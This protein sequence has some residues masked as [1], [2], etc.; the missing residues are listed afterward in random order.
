MTVKHVIAY[1]APKNKTMAHIMSLN[2]MISCV[3]GMSIFWFKTY[4]KQ[5][6]SLIEI[7]TSSMFEQ[8][9]QAETLNAKKNKS[10]YQR[11]GFKQLRAFHKQAMIKQQIYNN[12]LARR[13]GMDYSQGIHFQT[14]LVNMEEAKELTMNNQ[15]K[16]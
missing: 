6:F 16:R 11:Y 7:Q 10:Y 4:W 1:V 14:S 2:N 15:Q 12:M 9:L 13:S 3:M 8:F 5:V